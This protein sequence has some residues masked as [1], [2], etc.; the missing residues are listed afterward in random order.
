MVALTS[1]SGDI[2]R[3]AQ[4]KKS[5]YPEIKSKIGQRSYETISVDRIPDMLGLYHCRPCRF[6]RWCPAEKKSRWLHL[7][8]DIRTG[9]SVNVERSITWF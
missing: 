3:P 8:V 6:A 2:V 4:E 5:G 1:S 7:L 9:P